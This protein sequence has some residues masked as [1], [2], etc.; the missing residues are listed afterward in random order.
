MN[1]VSVTTLELHLNRKLFYVKLQI[2][3]QHKKLL[4]IV[5]VLGPLLLYLSKKLTLLDFVVALRKLMR[6]LFVFNNPYLLSTIYYLI[7][8]IRLYIQKWMHAR[9]FGKQVC[10][11]T[12]YI[13]L[14]LLQSLDFLSGYVCHKDLEMLVQL[15]KL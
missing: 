14:L 12:I 8:L 7:C 9:L 15:F 3:Y 4:D 6:Q 5:I 10:I 2:V 11:Q 1:H 13:K